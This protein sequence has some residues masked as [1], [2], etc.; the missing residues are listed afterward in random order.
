MSGDLFFMK[1][2]TQS[3]V[4]M[5]TPYKKW[6]GLVNKDTLKFD[7]IAGLIGALIVLPQAVAF[8]TIA[9]LPPQYGLYAA[10]VPAVI[11]AFFGS[12]RH[13]VS[14]PTTA[15]SLVVFGSI[16]VFATP[17]SAE[18]VS[19][20]LTLTFL[21]GVI[22]VLMAVFRMG[23][24][25]N[26]ISHTVTI[27]FT[28][29]AAILIATSQLKNFLG[30]KVPQGSD[31][32]ETWEFV[33]KNIESV[34]FYVILVA[35]V[36]LLSGFGFK[37]FVPKVPY[38]IP[39]IL[40][41]S[42]LGFV[43]NKYLGFDTTGIKTIGSIPASLPPL[44]LPDFSMETILK[45][46]PAAF[47]VTLLALTESV[48]IAKSI[49]IKSEQKIDGNQEFFGQGLSNIVGSFFSAYPAAGSFNRSGVNYEAGA[50]TPLSSVFAA[51]FLVVL[52]LI[53]APLAQF[54]P[55]AVMA[56]VLFLVAY[57][58]IDQKNIKHIFQTS[59]EESVIFTLTFLGT[60]F[61]ELEFAIFVGVIASLLFYLKKTS[62]AHIY[63]G[64]VGLGKDGERKFVKFTGCESKCPQLQMFMVNEEIYFGSVSA[65]EDTLNTIPENCKARLLCCKAVQFVDLA[66]AEFLAQE[67]K[68]HRKLG[69][70]FVISGLS[71]EVYKF[72]EKGHFIEVLGKDNL[73]RTKKEAV[74]DMVPKLNLDTCKTC[75]A[76]VFKECPGF[77]K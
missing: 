57:G 69:V 45:L 41:G 30:I 37:K 16:S 17:Q 60:L 72:L 66:G 54:L 13:L 52:V 65:L 4:T 15:I 43:L 27:A 12:S 20:V 21:V 36:T 61:L 62:Q 64:T 35:I 5:F 32:L 63:E 51:I 11:A 74:N 47:A 28:A 10:M 25:V 42:V 40:I 9:G 22:Q 56:G 29:G 18:F 44:S 75:T 24:L 2:F 8:A 1:I 33:F 70:R 50:K 7:F 68:R 31:F 67:A 19:L 71:D 55:V 77:D 26:F 73:F 53:L 38:M 49:A 46:I 76:R 3:L 39:A 6:L 58:L 34:H 23:S 14:G 48:S 59:R